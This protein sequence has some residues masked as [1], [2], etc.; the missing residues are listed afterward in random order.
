MPWGEGDPNCLLALLQFHTIRLN[1]KAIHKL[2]KK[3]EDLKCKMTRRCFK[4]WS[5]SI[6]VLNSGHVFT[7]K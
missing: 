3:S 2:H 4:T 6:D 7:H 5:I 1:D